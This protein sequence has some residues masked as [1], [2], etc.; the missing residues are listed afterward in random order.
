MIA[1]LSG[2]VIGVVLLY[3]WQKRVEIQDA[4]DRARDWVH[5]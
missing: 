2:I 5:K 4:I 3:G 1:F